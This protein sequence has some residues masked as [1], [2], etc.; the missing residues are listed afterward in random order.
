MAGSPSRKSNRAKA[1]A[2]AK[3]KAKATKPKGTTNLN[4]S[5]TDDKSRS[6]IKSAAYYAK[7]VAVSFPISFLTHILSTS[8]GAMLREKARLRMRNIRATR[9]ATVQPQAFTPA[10]VLN[11]GPSQSPT[12]NHQIVDQPQHHSTSSR[13]PYSSP[14]PEDLSP[15]PLPDSPA[16]LH[17]SRSPTPDV[18]PRS[19]SPSPA[20]RSRRLDDRCIDPRLRSTHME[21]DDFALQGVDLDLEFDLD[22]LPYEFHIDNSD[23]DIHFD[24]VN[25]PHNFEV[26]DHFDTEDEFYMVTHRRCVGEWASRWGHTSCW[27]QEIKGRYHCLRTERQ[28]EQ[29]ITNVCTHAYQGRVIIAQLSGILDVRPFP[30]EDWHL[31]ELWRT[32]MELLEPMYRGLAIIDAW[33]DFLRVVSPLSM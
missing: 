23:I 15:S 28:K 13:S 14:L 27:A 32:S 21:L 6:A 5:S 1:K 7:Y 29:F 18:P 2:K 10:P 8:N 12:Q 17:G 25:L 22:S 19:R 16:H 4:N 3:T 26:V 11:Q 24:L 31:R 30:K 20:H 33:L 9:A